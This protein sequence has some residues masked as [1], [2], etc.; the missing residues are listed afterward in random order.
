[1]RY[2][3]FL[4]NTN[5]FQHHCSFWMAL[6]PHMGCSHHLEKGL[7]SKAP[8]E[9][10]VIWRLKQLRSTLLH[11]QLSFLR[12]QEMWCC[13]VKKKPAVPGIIQHSCR[14]RALPSHFSEVIWLRKGLMAISGTILAILE[15]AIIS[16]FAPVLSHCCLLNFAGCEHAS[17]YNLYFSW[18]LTLPTVD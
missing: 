11:G 18:A 13:Q 10:R 15:H 4:K 8:G 14:V 16:F 17:G 12:Q 7:K 5:K 9:P 1:M 6:D 3:L 2:F